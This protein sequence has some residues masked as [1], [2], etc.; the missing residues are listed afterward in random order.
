[1]SAHSQQQPDLNNPM[2]YRQRLRSVLSGERPDRPIADLGG[3]V[4]SLN[5]TAYLDLK[6]YLGF[7]NQLSG[8]TV[9]FLNTLGELDERILSHFD[10]PFRRLYLQPPD[11]YE[12][13]TDFNGMFYDEW[14]VGYQPTGE[15]NERV[16]HP[17][18]YA[19]IEDLKRFAWPDSGAP[20]RVAGLAEQARQFYNQSDYVLVAGHISAGIFQ[21][22]WNLRGME[23]FMIDL[24]ADPVFAGALLDRVTEIHIGL[25]ERFLEAVGPF[26]DI[27]ETAD[28]LGGQN[29][30]LI[31]PQMYRQLI[32]PRHA[33][34]N[35][36]IR[37]RTNARILYHSCGA[38]EPL[39]DDL[40]EIG[41]DILN[42]IQPL[43]GHM[44]PKTLRIRYGDRLVF[45]GGL[46]VQRLLLHGSPGEVQD[47]VRRY[48]DILGPER[49]IMAPANSVQPGTPPENLVAAYEAVR[50]YEEGNHP[51][52]NRSGD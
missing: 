46:D 12:L 50:E 52:D 10:I 1:M 29:G 40:I 33:A 49:Y 51:Y 38:I 19:T 24:A 20:G 21:D 13:R 39:I 43:P 17:L 3:R 48:L 47:H 37:E 8:E 25:W 28:D 15:Y 44:D 35:A 5:T 11:S 42:P 9:T 4:A 22:C 31:S 6:S 34:L 41:V 45:H 7:G 27:V 16:R 30:L 14:G 23:Q 36:A 18:A 2:N 32:K 26:V